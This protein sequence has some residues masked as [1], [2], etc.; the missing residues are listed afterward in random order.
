MP[1]PL[2]TRYL[3]PLLN[4]RRAEC[5]ALIATAVADGCPAE[6]LIC[7]VVWPSMAQVERLYRDD[8]INTAT[9]QMATRI[10]R[11]VAD[12]LQAQLPVAT[13]NGRRVIVSCAAGFREELGAQMVA[14][15]FQADGW[16]VFFVGGGVPDDELLSLIGVHRPQ[17]LLLFG[18]DPQQVPATRRLI[19]LIREV[20]VCPT[21]NIV[22]SGGVFNRAEG[23]WQEVGADAFAAQAREVL[24][25]VNGLPAR[26]PGPPRRGTV[27]KRQRRRRGSTAPVTKTIS[28]GEVAALADPNVL[29]GMPRPRNRTPAMPRA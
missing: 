4:G 17:A 14:D 12:Q 2:L 7:D 13:P 10:N 23:L 11:T 5:F 24:E 3:Q 27:K 1:E 6:R 15:L 28:H 21:M 29:G 18:T 26:L 25:L 8:R 22:L 16:E 9:E 19:E 20:D